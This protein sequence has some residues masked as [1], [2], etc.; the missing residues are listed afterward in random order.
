MSTLM[1]R[2]RAPMLSGAPAC[3]CFRVDSAIGLKP[4]VLSHLKL[5][6]DSLALTKVNVDPETPYFLKSYH[7]PN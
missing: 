2:N 6:R 5:I 1:A 3:F 7:H 4:S